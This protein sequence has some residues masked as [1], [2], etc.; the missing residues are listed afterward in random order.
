MYEWQVQCNK[1]YKTSSRW[2]HVEGSSTQ[3]RLGGVKQLWLW[4]RHR[5]HWTFPSTVYIMRWIAPSFEAGG[6]EGLRSVLEQMWKQRQFESICANPTVSFRPWSAYIRRMLWHSVRN[7]QLHQELSERVVTV[8]PCH[9]FTYLHQ[10]SAITTLTTSVKTT[11]KQKLI[12]QRKWHYKSWLTLWKSYC[13]W[14][15]IL[16]VFKSWKLEQRDVWRK[17]Q[18]QQLYAYNFTRLFYFYLLIQ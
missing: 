9:L 6:N 15:I 16:K 1:L 17:Q 12:Y 10:L 5:R 8:T 3:D 18:Q 4:T 13:V 7:V 14:Y 2:L 11:C